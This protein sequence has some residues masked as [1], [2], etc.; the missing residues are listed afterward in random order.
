MRD[1]DVFLSFAGPDRDTA[2]RLRKALRRRRLQVW[3]DETLPVACG[4]TAGIQ[5]HLNASKIMLIVYSGAYPLRSACQ[6]ELTEAYLAGEREGDPLRRIM[7]INPEAYEHHLQPVQFADAKFV[8]YPMPADDRTMTALAEAV[9]KKVASVGGTFGDIS[10]TTRPRWYPDGSAGVPTFVGRYREQW[11]L[12]TALHRVD[13][14]MITAVPSGP[15]VAL[16]GMAGSGKST[17]AAAY[18][19]HFSSAFP[20][21]VFRTGLSGATADDALARYGDEVRKVAVALNLPYAG[22]AG[23]A[24]LIAAVADKLHMAGKPALWIIDD[25]PHELDR[26]TLEQLLLPAGTIVRT[27]MISRRPMF[28]GVAPVVELGAMSLE[29]SVAM[30]RLSREPDDDGED[31]LAAERVARRLGGHPFSLG[32]AA[33]QLADR[34]GLRSYA[35]HLDR[36]DSDPAAL[37]PAIALVRDVLAGLDDGPRLVLQVAA[38]LAPAPLPAAILSR[39]VTGPRPESDPADHL[40]ELR[41]LQLVTRTGDR[42]QVHA[43][44]LDATRRLL[45]PVVPVEHLVGTAADLLLVSCPTAQVVPHLAALAD[46]DLL[47]AERSA[48]LRRRLIEHYRL[49]GEPVAAAG[50]WDRLLAAG[51]PATTDLLTAATA[52]LEAGGYER[53]VELAR[54]ASTSD[55]ERLVAQGLDA[56]GRFDEANDWWSRVA[57]APSA[58]ADGEVAYIRSRRLRGEMSHARDRA[59]EL[60]TRLSGSDDDRLQA[61]RLE[62]A[63]IQLSTNQQQ[64]ARRTAE[65]V[66][67]HYAR[68]GLP[69]H[70]SAVAAQGVLAQAWLT[71]HLFELNPDPRRWKDSARDLWEMRERLRRSHGPLNARTLA[72]DVEYGFALLCLGRPVDVWAHLGETL[73]ALHR[74]FPAG[75]HTIMRATFLLAQADAQLHRYDRARASYQEA[76]D[77]LRLSL[78]PRHPETLA[79]QY[80]LGVALILTSS[81]SQGLRMIWQVLRAAPSVVGLRTDI[82]GQSLVAALLLPLLPGNVLRLLGR[83]GSN[84]D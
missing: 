36:I 48:R 52:H 66:V 84:A 82:F 15:V 20:G 64:E 54:R 28:G 60:V 44:V 67:E 8:R 70:A 1:H 29:D 41:R 59:G 43:I 55:G 32:L 78:G 65:A 24:E 57:S 37:D 50:Q 9:A 39:I 2:Q 22:S 17:L 45:P 76:Y 33:A 58:S 38:L 73:K 11:D 53:A 26:G 81:R 13:F 69:E 5:K 19:W 12:H 79:A 16:V 71:L 40:A 27:I 23:H 51:D 80:G 49:H 31:D 10:F 21:G 83:V 46:H 18:A 75:H 6:F 7:M 30:L 42:W 61:A 14:P 72:I 56:L 47:D 3:L 68:R 34:Q 63:V 35:E 74:R 25:V 4:I 77:G 62:L